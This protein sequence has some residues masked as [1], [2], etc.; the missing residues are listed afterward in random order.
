[1][2]SKQYLLYIL[3]LSIFSFCFSS[4]CGRYF[5]QYSPP[6]ILSRYPA[7]NAGGVG[8]GET[9]WVKFSKSIDTAGFTIGNLFGRVK[10]ADDMTASPELFATPTAEMTWSN[11]DTQLTIS[12]VFFIANPGNKVHIL[13]SREAF[14]DTDG[15]MLTENAILWDY[16]L[17]GF[18]IISRSPTIDATVNDEGLTIE[19][20]FN[21]PVDVTTFV[22]ATGE[23]HTAGTPAGITWEWDAS[24]TLLTAEA[25]D[26]PNMPGVVDITYGAK[27]IYG[28]VVTNGQLV[29]YNLQ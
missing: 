17:S 7:L 15:Q 19:A 8:S 25:T 24:N 1:M 3:L 4:G 22:I 20:V 26:W 2:K 5:S 13:S 18:N 27:D 14:T 23:S 10:V 6:V 29:R 16:T 28:N 9:I 21:N 11:S 12:N